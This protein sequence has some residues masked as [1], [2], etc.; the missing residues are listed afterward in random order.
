MF[1]VKLVSSH[2]TAAREASRRTL[3]FSIVMQSISSIMREANQLDLCTTLVYPI[4]VMCETTSHHSQF[5]LVYFCTVVVRRESSV[6]REASQLML[7]LHL[8]SCAASSVDFLALLCSRV[9]S[10]A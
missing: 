4:A 1:C 6:L 2:C 8:H 10:S 9:L 5:I 7:T 3:T